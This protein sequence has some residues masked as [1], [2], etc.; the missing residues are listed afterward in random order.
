MCLAQGPQRSDAGEAHTLCE[1]AVK[2]VARLLQYSQ[3]HLSRAKRLAT[4]W[5]FD[6]CRLLLSLETPND[7]QSVA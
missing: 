6:M 7:A 1:R 5:Q 2:T 4:M 3:I